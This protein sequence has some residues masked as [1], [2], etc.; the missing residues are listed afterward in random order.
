MP[1]S[2][3]QTSAEGDP[4][5]HNTPLIEVQDVSKDFGSLTAVSHVS[6]A[7]ERGDICGLV[8]S[9]GAGKTTLL[10]MIA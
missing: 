1:G 5:D 4:R 9:D 7:V 3:N 2:D 10:R 6:F 8:G